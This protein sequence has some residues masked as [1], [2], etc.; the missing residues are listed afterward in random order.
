M[1][2]SKAN[3]GRCSRKT[4]FIA[5][6]QVSSVGLGGGLPEPGSVGSSAKISI[7]AFSHWVSSAGVVYL[8]SRLV[9]NTSG[10]V[11][12]RVLALRVAGQRMAV[13]FI[14]AAFARS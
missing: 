13:V 11:Q 6:V 8:R 10:I 7:P 5:R 1:R 4:M 3:L 12:S 2:W 14:L 9:F